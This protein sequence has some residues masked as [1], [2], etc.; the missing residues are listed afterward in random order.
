[1]DEIRAQAR[2]GKNADCTAITA[3]VITVTLERL[4]RTLQ[5]KA[6]LWIDNGGFPRGEAKEGG[7]EELDIVEIRR[8]FGIVRVLQHGGIN[9]GCQEL[10][11]REWK[12]RLHSVTQVS[13][14]LLET[15]SLRKTSGHADYG[16]VRI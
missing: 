15:R 9:S 7:V 3:R 16:D 2:T 12:D 10:L 6:M 11:V 14:E 8:H 4:P 13:P 5:E 1:M